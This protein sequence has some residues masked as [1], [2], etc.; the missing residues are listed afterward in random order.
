MLILLLNLAGFALCSQDPRLALQYYNNGEY[1]KSA[2]LYK[3]LHL[4]NP[5]NDSYFGKYLDCLLNLN[6]YG[7]A[8]DLIKKELQK[9]PKEVQLF[10]SYGKLLQRRGELDKAEKQFKMAI[11]RLPA[12]VIYIHKL[13][14]EFSAIT[15]MDL[16]IKTYERGEELMK[17]TMKFTYNLADLYRK[18]G[19]MNKMLEYYV[20]GLIDGSVNPQNLESI[21]V[22][23]LP[24]DQHKNF[25]S[26]L[27]DKIQSHP[28]N[29]ALVETLQWTFIQSKDYA[30]ALRQAKSL[31]RKLNEGGS[32]IFNIASIAA[33]DRDYKTAIDGYSA[34]KAK[35]SSGS[36]YLEASRQVL[37]AR[38]K[39]IVEKNEYTQQDLIEIEKDYELLQKEYGT[40]RLIASMIIEFAELE[41]RYLNNIPKAI[42]IL[43]ELI[44]N[45]YIEPHLKAQAKL[46]LAD[47]YLISGER[48]EATLLYSQVDKDFLEDHL[49]EMARFRNAR[50]SYFAGDFAWAEEQFDI[51]K[52]ATSKLISNDAIDLSVFISDNLNQDTLGLALTEYSQAELKVFQN[53]FNEAMKILDSI[54]IKYPENSLEDD[55]WYLEAK[56]LNRQKQTDAAIKKY[57]K[58]IDKFKDGIRADNA[59]FEMAKIYDDQYLN[60][61][62]AKELY[63]KLFLEFSGSTLAV[64]AR[65]R[66]RV[67]RGDNIN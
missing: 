38:R 6:Q 54:V 1:E 24:A 28:E 55:V 45:S 47:Y 14:T 51:L 41:A 19:E 35:G 66:Y 30:N 17:G 63:E 62:K 53:Q 20:L 2:S 16:A 7:E 48:W 8:E 50:L 3:E 26:L 52:Q 4:K 31:D 11:E 65:K 39:Q 13:G 40:G 43:E 21:L 22:V 12:D 25:Q 37:I 49:G 9:R 34:V 18:S 61:E 44:K 58:I 33:N 57:E 32:R 56:I 15:R 42:S 5:G 60:Y 46:D 10:V 23:Y 27:Y 59:L 36:F 67:L 29:S 64:E